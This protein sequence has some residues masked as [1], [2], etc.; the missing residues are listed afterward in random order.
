MSD[1]KPSINR[2]EFLK[3]AGLA[4]LSTF[5]PDLLLKPGVAW[6]G[7]KPKNILIVV[8]DAWS[9]YNV[10]LYGYGRD[11]MP[12]LNRLAERAVVYHNNMSAGNFTTPGT[13]SLLTGAYPWTHR[14]FTLNETVAERFL[15]QNIFHNFPQY[16]RLAYTHNPYAD[17]ILRQLA[18]EID[19]QIQREKL[20]FYYNHFLTSLFADDNDIAALSWL[21]TFESRK[22]RSTYSLFLSQIIGPLLENVRRK[23][24][25]KYAAQFPRGVPEASNNFFLLEQATD[26]FANTLKNTPTP[27]LGYIHL[28]PPHTPY[29]TSRDFYQYFKNDDFHPPD[30][31]RH[32]LSENE[33][34]KLVDNLRR[35]YDEYLLYVDQEFNRLYGLLEKAGLLDDTWLVLTSDHGEMFERNTLKHT[36]I[37]MYRPVIH[38]PLLIFEPGRKQRQDIYLPTNGVDLL[39]TLLFLTG[40][41]IPET[42]EG[43][44]LPP[45]VQTDTL[46]GRS[47]YSMRIKKNAKYAPLQLGSF[48]QVNE[49]HK[50]VYYFGYP[51]IE[52]FGGEM[53]ELY[54]LKQD[55]E[56]LHDLAPEHKTLAS[57][58]LAQLKDKLEQVNRAYR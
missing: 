5:V 11:T 1:S 40:N 8:Y 22:E 3:I 19:D 42:C 21:R 51:E 16:Y 32:F 37:T 36:T 47:T 48:V 14:A 9:A 24:A 50:L 49:N 29:C 43:V 57:D 46:S 12:N 25:Q 18:A 54:D 44:V 13:A 7:E 52:Q 10:P 6:Q 20:F 30:K 55:P 56:E 4:S 34:Q 17:T 31:P 27:F 15:S 26:Y 23:Q 33:P 38:T 39:P 2:R 58:L 28:L 35:Q 45:Y 53:I 41:A